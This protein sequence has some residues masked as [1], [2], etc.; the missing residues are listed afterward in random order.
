[1]QKF[2]HQDLTIVKEETLYDGFF[3]LKKVYFKHKLFRGGESGIVERE[4]LVKGDA[5]AVIAYDPTLDNVVMVEQVRV[6]AYDTKSQQ[7]PWLLEIIAGLMEKG[8][9]PES[10]ALREA[11]EEAGVN[12]HHLTPIMHLWDSPG[13]VAERI[14]LFVGQ[15]DSTQAKGIHGLRQENE[16]IRVH[17]LPREQAYA[18]LEKG[19]INNGVAVVGLQWLQ[20]HYLTL[21][22]QWQK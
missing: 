18:L 12:L 3:Q 7:S 10:V 1:M 8:E 9:T 22:E 16:D 2:G 13:G 5:V 14:H 19:K 4:V 21:Q 20:L 11:Q 15:V 17:V 6:G